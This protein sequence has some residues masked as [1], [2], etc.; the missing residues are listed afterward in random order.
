M[1][2]W[3][4]MAHILFMVFLNLTSQSCTVLSINSLYCTVQY[5]VH[6]WFTA[7]CTNSA[8]HLLEAE[9]NKK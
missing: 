4:Y 6:S 2:P 5:N 3:S 9:Q 8:P 1:W 7:L